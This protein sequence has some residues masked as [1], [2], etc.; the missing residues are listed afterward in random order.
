MRFEDCYNI[1]FINESIFVAHYP[2][3][4][5]QK[6]VI[7]PCEKIKYRDIEVIYPKGLCKLISYWKEFEFYLE[8]ILLMANDNIERLYYNDAIKS[9]IR[10]KK[11]LCVNKVM[12]FQDDKTNKEETNYFIT[13]FV[14]LLKADNIHTICC[15]RDMNKMH[16]LKACTGICMDIKILDRIFVKTINSFSLKFPM[17]L[18]SLEKISEAKLIK[19]DYYVLNILLSYSTRAP[20][21]PKFLIPFNDVYNPELL[22]YSQLYK[23]FPVV[24]KNMVSTVAHSFI[25]KQMIF[26]DVICITIRIILPYEKFVNLNGLNYIRN[27]KTSDSIGMVKKTFMHYNLNESACYLVFPTKITVGY[28]KKIVEISDSY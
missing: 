6:I 20:N 18:Y 1:H 23:N 13:N 14:H 5:I 17:E 16:A 4:E 3:K 28:S 24:L 19:S 7:E 21:S 12:I 22:Y 9:I 10:N 2:G 27:T 26:F 8:Y 11:H 25:K 15:F